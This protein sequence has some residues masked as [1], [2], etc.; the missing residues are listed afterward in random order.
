[1]TQVIVVSLLFLIDVRKEKQEIFL[2][3]QVKEDIKSEKMIYSWFLKCQK[4]S[5]RKDEKGRDKKT[6]KKKEKNYVVEAHS[7]V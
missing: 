1:M 7:H 5:K 6:K 3:H 2:F 4:E